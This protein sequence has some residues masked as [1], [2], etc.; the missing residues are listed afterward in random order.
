[1]AVG[2]VGNLV[3]LVLADTSIV[4]VVSC[5]PAKNIRLLAAMTLPDAVGCYYSLRPYSYLKYR[6]YDSDI[7]Y[8][9]KCEAI[10]ALDFNFYS[11]LDEY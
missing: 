10:F 1:M 6:I 2:F 9:W 3:A 5:R 7:I 11:N 8:L 4:F